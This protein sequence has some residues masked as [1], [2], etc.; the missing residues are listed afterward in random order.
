MTTPY[1]VFRAQGYRF[2]V[3]ASFVS[4]ITRIVAL[5]PFPGSRRNIRGLFSLRGS[6]VFVLDLQ[7]FLRIP[8]A[9]YGP[10]GRI[11]VL[12]TQD[13]LFG[14]MAHQVEGMTFL[15]DDLAQK[16]AEIP[17]LL[18]H[19]GIETVFNTPEGFISEFD[20]AHFFTREWLA[21]AVE[22]SGQFDLFQDACIPVQ[23][24]EYSA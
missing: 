5:E 2:G 20:P 13:T 11:I 16:A 17:A 21:D 24:G 18:H 7:G 14:I 8:Q 4:E 9:P 6:S 19:P 12:R 15:P 10:N 1:L 23:D 3:R 22:D